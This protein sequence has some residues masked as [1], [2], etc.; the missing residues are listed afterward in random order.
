MDR[1]PGI[2][3]A[4][5][6]LWKKT[7]GQ[8]VLRRLVREAIGSLRQQYL[9]LQLQL[10]PADNHTEFM[11]WL[12]GTPPE[13]GATVWLRKELAGKD[14]TIVDVGANAGLFSLPLAEVVGPGSRFLLFE[15]NPRM[16]ARLAENIAL[17]GFCT[18][19][20][21]PV[22]VGDRAGSAFLNLS[23]VGNFGAARVD[24]PY[25]K[26]EQIE[27]AIHPLLDR[28]KAQDIRSIDLLKV[29]IEGL[30]DRAI[31]PFLTA[32]PSSLLPKRIFF[33]DAHNK[34]WQHDLLGALA[35]AGYKV[36]TRFGENAVYE[37]SSA[38]RPG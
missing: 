35:T 21:D 14:A 11:L 38:E 26:G 18:M 33:E 23:P 17:N 29:D 15:P 28:I 22:A 10:H 6:A 4:L 34:H 16:Q 32:A 13:H 2:D 19:T 12:N 1:D 9:G 5:R 36:L 24:I 30:E 7:R 37:R 20:I 27:I 25:A 3:E 8:P 31:V